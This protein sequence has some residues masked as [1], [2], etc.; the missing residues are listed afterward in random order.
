MDTI[1]KLYEHIKRYA[2]IFCSQK[3]F[4]I[5]EECKDYIL[6]KVTKDDMKKLKSFKGLSNEKTFA[7]V[8]VKRLL[9]DFLR[10]ENK[11]LP[12]N[13]NIA[14]EDET[15]KEVEIDRLNLALNRLDLEDRVILKL[16]FFDEYNPSEIAELFNTTSLK[17]SKRIQK[18]KERLKKELS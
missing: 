18:L 5:L 16:R 12:F 17:I 4:E 8:L 1:W 3:C 9:I 13:E 10:R 14:I 7:Y 6:D 15:F 2:G 11:K